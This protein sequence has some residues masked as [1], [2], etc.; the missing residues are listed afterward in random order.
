MAIFTS[1]SAMSVCVRIIGIDSEGY[2]N[3]YASD[4]H[5]HISDSQKK[6][7]MAFGTPHNPDMHK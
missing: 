6:T 2:T 3:T 7:Q 1:L 4:P 5:S